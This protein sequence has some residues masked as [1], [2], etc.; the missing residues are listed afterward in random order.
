MTSI[1]PD[2]D[3]HD[4]WAEMPTEREFVA[5][6][7]A[8]LLRW[9][10][11]GALGVGAAGCEVPARLILFA[12]DDS[13]ASREQA[14]S[15]PIVHRTTYFSVKGPHYSFLVPDGSKTDQWGAFVD[16]SAGHAVRIVV[17]PSAQDQQAWIDEHYPG[18]AE[19][20]TYA[21]GSR[22]ARIVARVVSGRR[23]TA[24]VVAY[25][26]AVYDLA[27]SNEDLYSRADAIC[28]KVLTSF[29]VGE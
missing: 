12:W 17:E 13:K 22:S 28:V 4:E 9:G 3:C 18:A 21:L 27:C 29:R 23:L 14:K 20:Q 26:G 16:A 19:S 11:L 2:D 25:D 10:L 6:K 24:M 5:R 1:R 7:G 15:P 8:M